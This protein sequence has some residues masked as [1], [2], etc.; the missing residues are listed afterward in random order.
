VGIVRFQNG[1]KSQRFQNGGK[2]QRFQNGGKSQR[3]QNGGKSQ[4]FQNGGKSQKFNSTLV[5]YSSF[6]IM[7][8]FRTVTVFVL[9]ASTLADDGKVMLKKS[10]EISKE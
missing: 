3:F 10:L 5:H 6:V 8:T 7:A 1:G 9:L 2:T 4:K